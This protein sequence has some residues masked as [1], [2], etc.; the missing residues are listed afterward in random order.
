M[1]TFRIVVSR[2]TIATAAAMAANASQRRGC[3]D[4]PRSRPNLLNAPT[5]DAEAVADGRLHQAAVQAAVASEE[6]HEGG[7]SWVERHHLAK[8]PFDLIDV[9]D[10]FG[11]RENVASSQPYPD[12]LAFTKVQLPSPTPGVSRVS[13][14]GT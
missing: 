14:S 1:A 13:P 10:E 9:A 6:W 4:I 8:K 2:V 7:D 12:G 3:S 5:D 11:S